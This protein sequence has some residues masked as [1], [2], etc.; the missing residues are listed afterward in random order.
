M[1]R[2]L[3]RQLAAAVG[4]TVLVTSMTVSV[5]TAGAARPDIPAPPGLPAFYSVPQPLPSGPPGTLIKS[6]VLPDSGLVGATL[7]RVMYTSTGIRGSAVPV[8]GMVAIPDG[9]PPAGGWPVVSWGHG[10]NGMADICAPS[11]GGSSQ[12]PE[13]NQLVAAGYAVTA[14]DYQGEGTPG[15]MP[16]IVG[17]SAARDTVNIVLAA[18]ALPGVSLSS[19]YV[20]WGHSEGGQ[21]AMFSL[22]GKRYAPHLKL[23]GVVA[24]AP[25]SQFQYIYNFLVTSPF[26]YYLL[27]VAGSYNSYY[28]NDRAPL[29][30]ILT[31]P[32]VALVPQLDRGC[33]SY[34]Q[35]VVNAAVAATPDKSLA[36]LV[37][38]NPFTVLKWA[39]L[40]AANDP[41]TFTRKTPVPLLIIQGGDDE[42]IP[43]VSTQL[44]ASHLCGIGQ[45]TERWVYS[46]QSHAGV[47]GPSFPDML[48]W[49][50]DRFTTKSAVDPYVPTA[51]G[52]SSITISQSS[53]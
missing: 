13:V 39:H 49:I 31:P 46:G 5:G 21:T 35:G 1:R 22:Y 44:L 4:L 36:D 20:V 10:T 43:V 3:V 33:S 38:Q 14:S 17:A 12:I 47:I 48:H 42:Q 51:G 32:A 37:P 45:P 52:D 11:L 6:E 30:K 26:D 9:A 34:V 41:G 16:Y 27:M 15:L 7:Y 25:P 8:T 53:C 18:H 19:S 40:L 28:G 24:G 2:V 29:N 23:R 50:G